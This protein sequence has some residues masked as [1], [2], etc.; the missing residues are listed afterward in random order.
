MSTIR[1]L[2]GGDGTINVSPDRI[3]AVLEANR[4]EGDINLINCSA[5]QLL[6]FILE[7]QQYAID[8]HV[9]HSVDEGER[10]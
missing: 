4:G 9:A 10:V 2:I 3:T 7:V 8:Q 5:E 1:L 6:S